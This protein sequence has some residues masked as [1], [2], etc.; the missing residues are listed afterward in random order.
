MNMELCL[1]I[2]LT[3][4]VTIPAKCHDFSVML[5]N[6]KDSH[7]LRP[8]LKFCQFAV[9]RPTRQ[10]RRDLNFFSLFPI[11]Y[12]FFRVSAHSDHTPKT[13]IKGGVGLPK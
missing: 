8:S 6:L 5:M 12:F 13:D 7:Y 10:N 11:F 2:S 1:V 4:G 3:K 9:L